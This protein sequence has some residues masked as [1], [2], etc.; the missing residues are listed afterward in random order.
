MI[1]IPSVVL[2]LLLAAINGCAGVVEAGANWLFGALMVGAFIPMQV[3]VYPL[4]KLMAAA[5]LYS[6]LP[7]IVLVHLV[8]AMPVMTPALRNYYAGLPQ[9]LFKAARIDGGGF[10]ASSSSWCCPCPRPS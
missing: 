7:G 10:C 3:M 2:P 6:S 8:F 9:E 4:V 1:A 5:G